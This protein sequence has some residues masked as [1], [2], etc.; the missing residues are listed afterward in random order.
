MYLL[1]LGDA[2]A[3]VLVRGHERARPGGGVLDEGP[4]EGASAFLRV[5]DGVRYAGVGHAGHE[6]DVRH[7]AGCG[8]VARHDG[9]VAVAHHLDVH[10]L[11]VRVRV[12]VV[13]P[14][15]GAYL[16][17]VACGSQRLVAVGAHAHD[18]AGAELVGVGVAELV[19]RERFERHAVPVAVAPDQH[20]EAP[21][22]VARSDDVAVA[23]HYQQRQ[24]ALHLLLRVFD[25]FDEIVFLIYQ[26]R[27]QF[28][29]I[30][31]PRAH[32]HELLLAAAEELLH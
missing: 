17:A 6:V 5:A 16:H 22:R 29:G 2:V 21:H 31:L 30:H 26:R 9:A 7:C 8:L 19:V 10:A 15:E 20:R 13:H 1:H 24:R 4:R 27:H 28:G 12:T 23:R 18:L 3:H 14:Q 32:G 25:A 11:V